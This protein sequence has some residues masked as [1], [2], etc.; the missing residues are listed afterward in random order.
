MKNYTVELYN[1]CASDA[2]RSFRSLSYASSIDPSNWVL[3]RVRSSASYFNVQYLLVSLSSSSS[4]L[5]PLPRLPVTYILP[6]IFP[7]VTCFRRQ[8][9]R[10]MWPIQ[11]AFLLFILRR[12]F[13]FTLTPCNTSVFT[14]SV[15]LTFSVLLQHHIWKLPRDL[16]STFRR[17]SFSSVQSCAPNVALY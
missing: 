11:L 6:L 8:F 7:W 10:K 1:F 4:C 15:H 14:R 5:R 13:L 12:M 9:L 17:P 3:H 2:V 16:W